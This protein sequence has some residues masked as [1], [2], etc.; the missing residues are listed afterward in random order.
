M[1]AICAARSSACISHGARGSTWPVSS[2]DL[3]LA[4]TAGQPAEMASSALSSAR[5]SCVTVSRTISWYGSM[6]KVTREGP[7][8]GAAPGASNV[9]ASRRGGTDSST[10]PATSA[11]PE[12]STRRCSHVEPA[13]QSETLLCPQYSPVRS[14]S[15]SAFHTRSGV[16]SM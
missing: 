7:C 12:P 4:N 9:I 6:S 11:M 15:V 1:R 2:S 3:R 10:V 5:F 13:C 16:L 8:G 14:A